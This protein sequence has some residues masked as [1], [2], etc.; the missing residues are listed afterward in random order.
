MNPWTRFCAIA[1]GIAALS[2]VAG[3]AKAAQP[4]LAPPQLDGHIGQVFVRCARQAARKYG[5]PVPILSGIARVEGG[6]PG[7]VRT[8]RNGTRDYGVMQVNEVWLGKLKRALGIT[9]REL[10]RQVCPNVIAAAYIL[11]K[12]H[13]TYGD[14]WQAVEAYHAGYGLT[15]GVNYAV[16]VMRFALNNG[17][18]P[19]RGSSR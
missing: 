12:Y 4:T 11:A 14:W 9:R 16:R 17:F 5:V 19:P 2:V 15:S 8:D 6:R 1:V 10:N 3:A 18:D 7:K 13:G